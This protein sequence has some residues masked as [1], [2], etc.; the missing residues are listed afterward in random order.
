MVSQHNPGCLGSDFVDQ[1]DFD[2]TETGLLLPPEY[3]FLNLA[4]ITISS[5][6]CNTSFFSMPNPKYLCSK[7]SLFNSMI[8]S[9]I[10]SGSAYEKKIGLDVRHFPKIKQKD[11]LGLEIRM[12]KSPLSWHV[13]LKASG[14]PPPHMLRDKE[15][16]QL[17]VKKERRTQRASSN[18]HCIFHSRTLRCELFCCGGCG[19][20]SLCRIPVLRV[21][22]RKNTTDIW[23]RAIACNQEL[24]RL[25]QK[26]HCEL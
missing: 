21:S 22:Y 12:K 20:P 6:K 8:A 4:C 19:Q 25:R 2:L 26:D 10:K 7:C 24:G 16:Y 11:H 18:R 9:S 5:Y 14:V 3:V 15:A 1:L 13:L 23:C 17:Q